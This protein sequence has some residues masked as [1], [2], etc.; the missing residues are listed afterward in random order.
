MVVRNEVSVINFHNFFLQL[1]Q[2]CRSF[3][4]HPSCWVIWQL[5]TRSEVWL[6]SCWREIPVIDYSTANWHSSQK[7]ILLIFLVNNTFRFGC[8]GLWSI[9]IRISATLAYA[10]T[11]FRFK[12]YLRWHPQSMTLRYGQAP[13]IAAHLPLRRT[14]EADNGFEYSVGRREGAGGGSRPRAPRWGSPKSVFWLVK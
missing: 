9:I 6:T 7:W 2:L 10:W 3:L 11:V 8:F 12:F 14:H 1:S 5:R 13:P 4:G